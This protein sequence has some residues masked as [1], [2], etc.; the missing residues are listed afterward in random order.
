M[1]NKWEKSEVILLGFQFKNRHVRWLYKIM[2]NKKVHKKQL[3]MQI[4]WTLLSLPISPRRT[5]MIVTPDK[6]WDHIY[7]QGVKLRTSPSC[8]NYSQYIYKKI[9]S[10]TSPTPTPT[11]IRAVCMRLHRD[12]GF[13]SDTV[14]HFSGEHSVRAL[15]STVFWFI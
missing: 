2:N 6:K 1:E 13:G 11:F 15:N 12:S 10:N 8:S 14:S 5:W 3:Q 7:L 4:T 9:K